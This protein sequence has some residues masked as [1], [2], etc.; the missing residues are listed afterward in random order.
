M[1]T[2]TLV[3]AAAGVLLGAGLG[4]TVWW[5]SRVRRGHVY[6]VVG[7]FYADQALVDDLARR[8]PGAQRSGPGRGDARPAHEAGPPSPLVEIFLYK[9]GKLRFRRVDGEILP[10]FSAGEKLTHLCWWWVNAEIALDSALT[11][12]C[13]A[14]QSSGVLK[15][16][17]GCT[18]CAR[19]R[20]AAP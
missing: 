19:R 15:P 11:S 16:V 18:R 17:K 6:R 3:A 4:A 2:K 5:S 12:T 10:D 13:R 8:L 1:E 7:R 14:S 20:S 9:S